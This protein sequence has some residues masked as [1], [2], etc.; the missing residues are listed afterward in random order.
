VDDYHRNPVAY[1]LVLTE[2][3]K[4]ACSVVSQKCKNECEKLLAEEDLERSWNRFAGKNDF[5]MFL[6]VKL[7]AALR[8]FAPWKVVWMAR[9]RGLCNQ[10]RGYP[11][12][13]LV[14]FTGYFSSGNRDASSVTTEEI[15]RM[16]E[17]RKFRKNVVD[18]CQMAGSATD[19]LLMPGPRHIPFAIHDFQQ[20]E[21][22]R[23]YLQN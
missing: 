7:F 3:S 23:T 4:E 12:R 15:E 2:V 22:A 14:E 17:L 8:I 16:Q 11:G 18:L 6:L 5:S 10:H 13:S 1:A 20:K 19:P 21:R 9:E